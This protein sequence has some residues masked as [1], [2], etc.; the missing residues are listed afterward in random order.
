M[1]A[2]RPEPARERHWVCAQRMR[3]RRR[4]LGLTQR[5]V[6]GRI[7]LLGGRSTNRALSAMEN[8]RGLDLGLLPEL[9]ASLECTVTYLL[10]L[11]TEPHAWHPDSDIRR[12]NGTLPVLDNAGRIA[13]RPRAEFSPGFAASGPYR[14]HSRPTNANGGELAQAADN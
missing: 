7:A 13:D 8:G 10:G 3:E 4:S 9:A 1:S 11:A 12:T 14:R 2:P 6:V 5:E